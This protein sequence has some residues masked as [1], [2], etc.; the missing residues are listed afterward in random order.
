VNYTPEGTFASY[1][2][3]QPVS[4][5]L[6]LAFQELEPIYDSDYKYEGGDGERKDDTG[7]GYRW[8]LDKDNK[9]GYGTTEVGY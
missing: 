9:D 1:E 8:K 7:E 6:T 4:V 5:L 2:K 3:G